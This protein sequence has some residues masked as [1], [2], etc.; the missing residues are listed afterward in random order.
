MFLI[1]CSSSLCSFHRCACTLH[2][3]FVAGSV[4]TS[5]RIFF[6]L[7]EISCEPWTVNFVC[8]KT[9]VSFDLLLMASAVLLRSRF[10][11]DWVLYATLS[12]N[13]V[14]ILD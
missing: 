12:G 5:W 14:G 3:S 2:C 11:L 13:I 7:F 9:L 4:V 1:F 8:D 6:P 10:R